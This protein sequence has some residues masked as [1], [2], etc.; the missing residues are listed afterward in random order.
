MEYVELNEGIIDTIHD[1]LRSKGIMKTE[2]RGKEI[3]HGVADLSEIN[4]ILHRFR[5][6]DLLRI[7]KVLKNRDGD[8][9][10]NYAGFYNAGGGTREFTFLDVAITNTNVKTLDWLINNV[11]DLYIAGEDTI[12]GKRIEKLIA[13]G[14]LQKNGNKFIKYLLR[15]AS[16]QAADGF[17]NHSKKAVSDL[18]NVVVKKH[19]LWGGIDKYINGI[20][21]P[22]NIEIHKV[23]IDCKI[24]RFATQDSIDFTKWVLNL[25]DY[26]WKNDTLIK[27]APRN[28][29][30]QDYLNDIPE[31]NEYVFGNMKKLGLKV[32]DWLTDEAKDIFLF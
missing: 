27:K 16:I 5:D 19:R 11:P 14:W 23:L 20:L 21:K 30:V 10:F 2:W 6:D 9:V 22:E 28:G 4:T 7:V 29:K 31:I 17:L 32:E 12:N 25:T 3:K 15:N 13:T 1:F 8:E 26:H 24:E 18:L